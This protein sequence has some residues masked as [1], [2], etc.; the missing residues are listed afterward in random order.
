MAIEILADLK[1]EKAIITSD[2]TLA[3]D[4]INDSLKINAETKLQRKLLKSQK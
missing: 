1:L 4:F 3:M 2:S